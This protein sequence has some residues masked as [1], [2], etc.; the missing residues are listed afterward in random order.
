MPTVFSPRFEVKT[1][2]DDS[3]TSA[4]ATAAS[5]GTEPTY[6][7]ASMSMMSIASFA[8]CAT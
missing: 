5:P 7:R 8:V 4:P 3:D 1:R 6:F 2:F